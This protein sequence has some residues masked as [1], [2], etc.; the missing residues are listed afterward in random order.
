[1]ARFPVT[2]LRS[3]D[4]GTP[5]LDLSLKFYCEVWGL[6]LV[7]RA[8]D[9]IYLRA[10]DFLLPRRRGW[11]RSA[12]RWGGRACSCACDRGGWGKLNEKSPRFGKEP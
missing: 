3:V 12:L 1:M 8:A 2:A 5:D 11:R 7:T 10:G 4:L 6:E 9:V